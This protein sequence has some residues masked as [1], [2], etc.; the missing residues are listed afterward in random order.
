MNS[1]FCNPHLHKYLCKMNPQFSDCQLRSTGPLHPP[2][3]NAF[4]QHRQLGSA[5][6]YRAARRLRPDESSSVKSFAEKTKPISVMPDEF[7]QIATAAAERKH[8]TGEGILFQ[9]RLH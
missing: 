5:Q 9:R 6:Q 8:V 4:Q 3:I 2:P 7:D 1:G